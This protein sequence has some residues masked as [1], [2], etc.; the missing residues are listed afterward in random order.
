MNALTLAEIARLARER[1]DA[2]V[3]DFLE[4]GAG[5]EW[6]LRANTET[7]DRVRLLPRVLAG[8][9]RSE[10][11]TRILDR[12]WVAPVAI[13]PMAY[14][15]LVDPMGEVATAR[16]AGTA[17]IPLIVSTFAG[18]TFED[19]AAEA[20]SPLWLQVYCFRDRST[21]RRLIERAERAGFEA[22]VLTVDAPHLGRR[23]RDL[24]NDFRL[25]QGIEPANLTGTGFSSPSGHAQAEFDPALDWSVLEWLRSVSSLPVLLKGVLSVADARMAVAAGADGIVV[26]NHGGRQLDGVPATLEVLPEIASA[27]AGDCA[28]LL[29][30]GIRRGRDVLAALALGAD[31]VLLGRPILHGL[32]AGRQPGAERVLDLITAELAD[33]MTLTGTRTVADAG[34]DLVRAAAL[35]V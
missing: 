16:A 13:A 2:A 25:P 6:T 20:F 1:M 22:L 17:G 35:A 9:G 12:N 21:T 27:V 24:R 23:L 26:S 33:A 29:D 8:I 7:F 19:I 32:A 15:T 10:T 11:G 18:R 31:A 28:V 14:H 30:G 5:E 4:G 34:P 3:W